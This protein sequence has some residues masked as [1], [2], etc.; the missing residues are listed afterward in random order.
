MNSLSLVVA[1]HDDR[2]EIIGKGAEVGD[3]TEVT[4]VD[5]FTKSKWN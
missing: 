5:R 2:S 1:W 4:C 3:F